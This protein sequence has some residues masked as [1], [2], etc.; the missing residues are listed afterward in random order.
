RGRR[1]SLHGS[2]EPLEEHHRRSNEERERCAVEGRWPLED[3]GR[4]ARD[5]RRTVRCGCGEGVGHRSEAFQGA[6]GNAPRPSCTAP[7][8]DLSEN[9]RSKRRPLHGGRL[10]F[11]TAASFLCTSEQ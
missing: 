2:V 9:G 4:S 11:F 1:E 10:F 7:L 3:S 8:T 6:R 5:T